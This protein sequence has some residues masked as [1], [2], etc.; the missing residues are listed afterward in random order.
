MVLE[1]GDVYLLDK[2]G[3]KLEGWQPKKLGSRSSQ[4]PNHIKVAQKDYLI[5]LQDNRKLQIFNRKGENLNKVSIDLD[6]KISTNIFIKKGINAE[7][8]I[9]TTISSLGE[10]I[11]FNLEG[12][13]ISKKQLLAPS[14]NTTFKLI[15]N[16][17]NTNFLLARQDFSKLALLDEN[18]TLVFE[19][20]FSS[21]N[22]KE[23]QYFSVKSNQI[24][25]VTDKITQFSYLFDLK[26]TILAEPFKSSHKIDLFYTKNK[27]NIIAS[28]QKKLIKLVQ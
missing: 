3:K 13:I 17:N 28:F 4:T 1:N 12:N 22:D 5:F 9:L 19:T 6:T 11:S 27:L 15:I 2:Q 25:A 10:L 8:T 7:K 23:I 26:G 21:K 14:N 24:I 20:D 18:G 16:N